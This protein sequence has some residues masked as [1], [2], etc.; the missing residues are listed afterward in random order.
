M[1]KYLFALLLLLCGLGGILAPVIGIDVIVGVAKAF[2]A[3][4]SV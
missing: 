3:F 2:F 1:V 4:G